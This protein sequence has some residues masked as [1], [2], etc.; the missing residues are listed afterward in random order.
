MQFFQE[1]RRCVSEL[2]I[3]SIEIGSHVGAKNLDHADFDPLYKEAE[4]LGITIFVHPWDMHNLDGRHNKY[5]LPWLVGKS[6]R[7]RRVTRAR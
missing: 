5:W 4:A 2:G 7:R 1:L 6:R 3:T